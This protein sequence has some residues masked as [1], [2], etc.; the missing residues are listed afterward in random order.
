M[1]LLELLL[2]TF[3]TVGVLGFFAAGIFILIRCGCVAKSFD[4]HTAKFLLAWY[5][6]D[7]IVTLLILYRVANEFAQPTL[8]EIAFVFGSAI[9]F[10]LDRR[11]PTANRRD[12]Q[13]ARVQGAKA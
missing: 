1:S 2:L 13:G 9:A 6:T 11:A 12:V 3:S 8:G 7:A 10:L 5:G 4:Y